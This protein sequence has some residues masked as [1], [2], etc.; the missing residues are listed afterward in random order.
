MTLFGH[1]DVGTLELVMRPYWTGVDPTAVATV[2]LRRPCEDGGRDGQAPSTSQG[3]PK[4]AGSPQVP[5]ETMEEMF[6]RSLQKKPT[7]LTPDF[8]R[9]AS[10][11]VREYISVILRHCDGQ[12]S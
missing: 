12:W 5:E 11:T 2:L 9:L 8:K 4:V 7:L 3:M 10:S 1:K 6:P